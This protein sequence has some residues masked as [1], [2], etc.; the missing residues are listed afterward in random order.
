MTTR[1]IKARCPLD[2]HTLEMLKSAMADLQLRACDRI[3][4]VART[5]AN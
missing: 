5:I 4:K 3:P 2:E 1:A